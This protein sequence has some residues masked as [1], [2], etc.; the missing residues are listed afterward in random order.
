MHLVGFYYQ[1]KLFNVN[2]VGI[3]QCEVRERDV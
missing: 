1:D 2:A 3:F